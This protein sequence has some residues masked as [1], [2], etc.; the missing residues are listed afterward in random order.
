MPESKKERTESTILVGARKRRKSTGK[1]VGREY[2][3]KK[4]KKVR[5]LCCGFHNSTGV[6]GWKRGKESGSKVPRT[7]DDNK[8]IAGLFRRERGARKCIQGG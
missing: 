5:Y 6:Y 3:D 7:E 8:D 2:D 1:G 4:K